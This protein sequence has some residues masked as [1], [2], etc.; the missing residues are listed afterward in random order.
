MVDY[1]DGGQKKV[2]VKLHDGGADWYF[3]ENARSS[4]G[5]VGGSCWGIQACLWHPLSHCILYWQ[6]P[7]LASSEQEQS[8]AS[9]RFLHAYCLVNEYHL[10]LFC[11]FL[12]SLLITLPFKIVIIA[13]FDATGNMKRLILHMLKIFAI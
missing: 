10:F 11:F 3:S 4:S 9:W 12:W 2:L 1:L 13:W 8:T 5:L 7:L 6:I